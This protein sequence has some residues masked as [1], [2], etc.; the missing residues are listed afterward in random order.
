MAKPVAETKPKTAPSDEIAAL[1]AIIRALEPL[2]EGART[3]AIRYLMDRF[4][5]YFP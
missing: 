2:D 1:M 3:R 4:Q 5:V